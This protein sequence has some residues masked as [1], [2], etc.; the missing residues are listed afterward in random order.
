MEHIKPYTIVYRAYGFPEVELS[1]DRE[2]DMENYV[3]IWLDDDVDYVNYFY[4]DVEYTPHWA[5]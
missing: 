1:F 3:I 2:I 5:E 4:Y